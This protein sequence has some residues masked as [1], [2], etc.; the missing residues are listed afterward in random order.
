MTTT[1]TAPTAS[2]T[3]TTAPR[4][5]PWNAGRTVLVVAG[6]LLALSGVGAL[7]GGATAVWAGQQRD[8]DGYLTSGPG[9]FATDT[10]A[11]SAP[12]LHL[13]VTGPD[14]YGQGQLG[15]IRIQAQPADPGTS[16]FIGIGPAKDVAAYLD[17]VNHVQVS[18]LDAGPFDVT[19][20]PHAGGQPAT[21]PAAQTFWAAT[22]AGT[23]PRTLTWPITGGDWAVVIMNTN[24]SAGVQTDVTAGASLPILRTVA[25]I[26]FVAGGLLLVAGIAMIVAP[27]TTRRP[28]SQ[29]TAGN[30]AG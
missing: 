22:D 20:D 10:Y 27:I 25:I 18:D 5:R 13:D 6:S 4:R 29:P 21:D 19:Y 30:G 23:G 26:A 9:R 3:P 12:S 8:S 7:A 1:P 14:L 15:E 16:L 28:R 2:S 24:A 17:P 11:I